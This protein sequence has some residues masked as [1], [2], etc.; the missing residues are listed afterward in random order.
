MSA[1]T[2]RLVVVAVGAVAIV[3]VFL[4]IRVLGGDDE[5][6]V[7][8]P[9]VTTAPTTTS[10]QKTTTNGTPPRPTPPPPPRPAATVIRIPIRGGQ[11]AGGR[12][13][14]RVER[15][16]RV[17]VAVSSDDISDHV[18]VHGYDLMRDVGPGAP[19]QIRFRAT[20]VGRF[21]IE[22]ED[23]GLQ[24]AELEVRP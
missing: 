23:R 2:R 7:A 8:P 9:T 20:L 11:V 17:V 6:S 18:H 16:D 10:G 1:S 19:A 4:V 15:G 24:I 21:E 12:K 22:L 3:A 5:N 14:V 13:R